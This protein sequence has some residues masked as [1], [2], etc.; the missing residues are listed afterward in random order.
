MNYKYF[1]DSIHGQIS[2]SEIS[3]KIIDT[4]EYQRLR[5]IKQL[6]VCNYVFTTAV[7][8][9]FEHS[10]GVAHLG[11]KLLY[12]LRNNQ[13]ELKITDNDIINVEIAG[14]CHDLGHGPWSHIF[15]NEYI[16]KHKNKD[17][18]IYKTH[19][20]RSIWILNYI[21]NKYNLNINKEDIESISE[22]ILPKKK[23]N[24][25]LFRIINNID[26]GIDVDKF[27]YIAR[28]SYNLNLDFTFNFEK[29]FC[30]MRVINNE[31]CYKDKD[32]FNIFSLFITRFRLHKQICNHPVVKSIEL[33]IIDYL[34]V[35]DDEFNLIEMI[36]NID[37]FVKLT[38]N[39][40]DNN[41]IS[42]YIK[43]DNINKM[44]NILNNLEKRHI[45]KQIIDIKDDVNFDNNFNNF[46]S[47][48]NKY[49]LKIVNIN[50]KIS[51]NLSN[52]IKF[53]NKLDKN[54]SFN[55]SNIEFLKNNYIDKNIL[56]F[57]NYD[58]LDKI[59]EVKNELN[60]L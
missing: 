58:N 44:N 2:L 14:L 22:M 10:I 16:N 56:F 59:N 9:R 1:N 33:M 26:N 29:I 47:I 43:N 13:P 53:Y 8:T 60:K 57:I 11:K 32:Y 55:L 7:H 37:K 35:F 40:L 30:G 50:I 31:I 42:F 39:I 45:Y 6:G 23:N 12:I 34:K 3:C 38:D 28:D 54:N 4:P 20:E 52:N 51:D 18:I 49:D 36:N 46:I 21:I 15:D 24:S 17:K 25:F 5:K 48:I 19:E 41:I 27:D